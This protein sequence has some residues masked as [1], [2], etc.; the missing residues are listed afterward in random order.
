M[1]FSH[2]SAC[3]TVYAMARD[4]ALPCSHFFA[5]LSSWGM[6]VHANALATVLEMCLI[7]LN[8]VNQTDPVFNTATVAFGASTAYSIMGYYLSYFVPI[9]LRHTTSKDLFRSSPGFSLGRASLVLG[10]IACVWII[11]IVIVSSALLA[12]LPC[13]V[14]SLPG[15]RASFPRFLKNRLTQLFF[16]C[17]SRRFRLPSRR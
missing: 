17:G 15:R 8:L 4:G 3:R 6:P 9:M 2:T 11:F 7:L 5:K 14:P 16:K 1:I 10:A 13:I 12:R